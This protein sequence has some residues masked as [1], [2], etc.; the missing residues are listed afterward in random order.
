MMNSCHAF[1]QVLIQLNDVSFAVLERIFD[2]LMKSD[3]S[4][5]DAILFLSR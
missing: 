5:S 2:G 4:T 1:G 3:G